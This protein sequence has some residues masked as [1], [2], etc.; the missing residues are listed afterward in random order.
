MKVL[1][2]SNFVLY[3]AANYVNSSVYDTE[4]FYEDLNR[5]KYLKKLFYR[6]HEKNELRERLILNHL[7]T[8][9]NIFEPNAN[10][11]MLFYRLEEEYWPSLKTF[12]LFLN[13]MPDVVY[14]IGEF[15]RNIV[16]S[17]VPVNIEIINALRKV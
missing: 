13:Y 4:E 7:I 5:Y 3:A 17:D 11:R 6:Y 10:T 14:H 9:Y 15:N 1:D 2:E 8:L 12:L 16:S